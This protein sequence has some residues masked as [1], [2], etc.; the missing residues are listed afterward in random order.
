[1]LARRQRRFPDRSFVRFAVADDDKRPVRGARAAR[2][3]RE[4]ERDRHAVT[5]TA[6]RRLD[7]W[8]VMLGMAAEE[9]VGRAEFPQLRFR[10]E[11]LVRQNRVER[12]AAVP[13]AQQEPVAPWPPRISGIVAQHIVVHHAQDLYQREGGADVTALPR[14]ERA[15]DRA[16]QRFRSIVQLNR[17]RIAHSRTSNGLLAYSP[18]RRPT[19]AC[20]LP[21][22][23][24][25]HSHAAGTN[26]SGRKSF[27]RISAHL[28]PN[29]G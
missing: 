23:V 21:S 1:M 5:E 28:R 15:D 19:S 10:E 2:I 7:A 18:A 11:S 8:N 14:F 22:C 6:G 25:R 3:Q 4:P 13:L 16:P 29:N 17:E 20:A 9:A 24:A 12:Q 27:N 26:R